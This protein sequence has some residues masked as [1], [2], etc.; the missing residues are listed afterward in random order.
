MIEINY[1]FVFFVVWDGRAL[2]GDI[3]FICDLQ[4][5]VVTTYLT[6]HAATRLL[7]GVNSRRGRQGAAAAAIACCCC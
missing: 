7:R 1:G 3:F 6:R 4:I 5:P 2:S